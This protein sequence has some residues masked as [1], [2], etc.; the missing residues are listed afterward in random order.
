MKFS[1]TFG[2]KYRLVDLGKNLS[3]IYSELKASPCI[4]RVLD[5]G[6]GEGRLLAENDRHFAIVGL[7]QDL[8]G[9]EIAENRKQ[10]D[11]SVVHHDINK[12]LPFD[13][14]VFDAVVF[15]RVLHYFTK[16]KR[17]FI[18]KEVRRVLK[19][20][21]ILHLAVYSKSDWKYV[22]SSLDD[23]K[24]DLIDCGHFYP[25]IKGSNNMHFFSRCEIID[26]LEQCGFEILHIKEIQEK[27]GFKDI[28]DL[29]TYW[30]ISAKIAK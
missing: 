5:L 23:K 25:S 18:L 30:M 26:D 13:N 17:R 1:Y 15:W 10:R 20:N 21:S 8:A 12:K 6:C 7:D 3:Q 22:L 2:R 4:G 29:N 16:T 27:S 24:K 9:L 14:S 28:K 11:D 19:E